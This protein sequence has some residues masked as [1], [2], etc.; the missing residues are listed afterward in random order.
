MHAWCR[1]DWYF[2][3]LFMAAMRPKEKNCNNTN[4]TARRC[5][6]KE[7]MAKTKIKKIVSKE[8]AQVLVELITTTCGWP[9]SSEATVELAPELF[10]GLQSVQDVRR[11]HRSPCMLRQSMRHADNVL[12]LAPIDTRVAQS[13]QKG[14]GEPFRPDAATGP[15]GPIDPE[16]AEG[17]W[18]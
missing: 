6:H 18:R 12:D 1:L 13:L 3:L 9:S 4:T 8:Q 17:C 10:Q 5:K 14:S 15:C 2:Y 16:F 11:L 7:Y